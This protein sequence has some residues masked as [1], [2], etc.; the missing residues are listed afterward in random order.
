MKSA[1]TSASTRPASPQPKPPTSS[2][3]EM[4]TP[5]EIASLR[6]KSNETA[7]FALKAFAL[8][9]QPPKGTGGR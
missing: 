4:L 2:T 7:D 3:S 1:K 8:P 9:S 6:R 5:S